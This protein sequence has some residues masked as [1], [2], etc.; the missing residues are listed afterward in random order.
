M[1]VPSNIVIWMGIGTKFRQGIIWL[2]GIRIGGLRF[3]DSDRKL[4]CG[5]GVVGT[6][7]V[8]DLRC[9]NHLSRH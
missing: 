9:L 7:I 3:F 4:F 5:P 1:Q 8:F 2:I 6:G